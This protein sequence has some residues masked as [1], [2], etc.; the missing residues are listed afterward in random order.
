MKVLE[1]IDSPRPYLGERLR[2]ARALQVVVRIDTP[3]SRAFFRSFLKETVPP[4]SRARQEDA[5][6]SM[7]IAAA[8]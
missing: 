7:K 6:A 8:D 5:S 3:E 2:T 4:G 1:F